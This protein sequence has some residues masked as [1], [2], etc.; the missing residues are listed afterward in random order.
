M[1]EEVDY[2]PNKYKALSSNPVPPKKQDKTKQ[3]VQMILWF[4]LQ[5]FNF[6]V[7]LKQYAFSRNCSSIFLN[8]SLFLG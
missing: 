5:V 1:V 4:D 3:R 2:L 6:T 8:V 7:V